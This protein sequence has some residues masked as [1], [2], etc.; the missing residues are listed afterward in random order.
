MNTRN[1]KEE[2]D[3]FDL[4]KKTIDVKEATVNMSPS[5]D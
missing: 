1:T 3:F 2:V 4:E 5:N